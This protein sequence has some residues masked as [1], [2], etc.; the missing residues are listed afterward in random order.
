MVLLHR[1]SISFKRIYRTQMINKENKDKPLMP[2]SINSDKKHNT[3]HFP[4]SLSVSES[5]P[6]TRGS[7]WARDQTLTTVVTQA[8]AVT[9]PY[10]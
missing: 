2:E 1:L 8:A 7:S 3:H 5:A 6:Q 10:L 4:L 9:T